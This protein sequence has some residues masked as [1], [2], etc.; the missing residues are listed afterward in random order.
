MTQRPRSL[1]PPSAVGASAEALPPRRRLVA[2]EAR[3]DTSEVGEL[4]AGRD[5]ARREEGVARGERPVR[6][7]EGGRVAVHREV[8]HRHLV[9]VLSGQTKRL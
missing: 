7:D 2:E 8:E 5:A 1:D 4:L 3:L 9:W 6:R